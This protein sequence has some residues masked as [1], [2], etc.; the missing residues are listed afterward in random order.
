MLYLV[1][2]GGQ[3]IWANAR[4]SLLDLAVDLEAAITGGLDLDVALNLRDIGDESAK[5]DQSAATVTA[6]LGRGHTL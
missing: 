4:T 3:Q 5:P 1:A 2:I 6:A